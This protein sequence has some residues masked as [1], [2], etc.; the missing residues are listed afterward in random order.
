MHLS[1]ILSST[2][3]LWTSTN[4]K[5]QEARLSRA[6]SRMMA[7]CFRSS[8]SELGVCS[9]A[10]SSSPEPKARP[11]W[12]HSRRKVTASIGRSARRTSLFFHEAKQKESRRSR[13]R[14]P[15]PPP[16]R[17]SARVVL[18]LPRPRSL[19]KWARRGRDRT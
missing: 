3:K 1:T 13:K 14:S 10:M 6:F 9:L 18:P 7:E 2:R 11:T 8:R 16:L 12:N 17:T 4:S 15:P 5:K 19:A